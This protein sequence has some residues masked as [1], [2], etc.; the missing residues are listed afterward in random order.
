MNVS[1]F[2]SEFPEE[3]ICY[4]IRSQNVSQTRGCDMSTEPDPRL[5]FWGSFVFVYIYIFVFEN[6]YNPF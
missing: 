5:R 3:S 4:C 6:R 2:I 1:F